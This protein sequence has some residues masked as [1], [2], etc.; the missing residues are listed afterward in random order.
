MATAPALVLELYYEDQSGHA[1]AQD[2][3]LNLA[4]LVRKLA[5]H[6][7]L[8]IDVLEARRIERSRFN[9]LGQDH[10]VP[11]SPPSRSGRQSLLITNENIGAAGWAGPEK[12]CISRQ[13]MEDK[14]RRG[15]N[16]AD[17]TI[18]EWLHT[19]EG[20]E[21]NGRRVPNPDRNTDYG[22]PDASGVG[23]DGEPTWYCWYSYALG[24]PLEAGAAPKITA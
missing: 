1:F 18:H 21:I 20:I 10:D 22:Y 2:S 14:A 17:I 8:E 19:I 11:N 23:G 15:G 13:E 6:V 5:P 9:A 4:Q 3:R 16:S 12:G 7:N 24:S